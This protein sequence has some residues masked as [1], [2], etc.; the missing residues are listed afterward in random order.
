LSGILSTLDDC[1]DLLGRKLPRPSI[2][3]DR[4]YTN[5][6]S[7]AAD[8]SGPTPS[9]TAGLPNGSNVLS[10]LSYDRSRILVGSDEVAGLVVVSE[11]EIEAVIH[12]ISEFVN[13]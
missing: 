12:G 10:N 6:A 8:I 11:T 7:G 5:T 13:A 2:V 4:P 1:L 3:T 9:D